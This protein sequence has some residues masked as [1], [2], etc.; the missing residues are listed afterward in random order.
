MTSATPINWIF[1]LAKHILNGQEQNFF[2]SNKKVPH[3]FHWS[4]NICLGVM[5]ISMKA[6]ALVL[7]HHFII[8]FFRSEWWPTFYSAMFVVTI[9]RKLSICGTYSIWLRWALQMITILCWWL[10]SAF[11][12]HEIFEHKCVPFSHAHMHYTHAISPIAKSGM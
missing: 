2:Q 11:C 4:R 6:F 10:R 12:V 8:H 3:R 9:W 7:H 1:K 5:W